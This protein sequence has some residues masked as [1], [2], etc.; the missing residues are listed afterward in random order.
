VEGFV[1]DQ[2]GNVVVRQDRDGDVAVLTLAHPP[3]NALSDAVRTG[4]AQGL[5]AALADPAVRAVVIRGEGRGFS[6]GADIAEFGRSRQALR[7]GELCLAIEN[8]AKPVIAAIHGMALGGGLELALAAHYR[9]AAETAVL[10]LPEVNLG[11][12]PGAGGTQRLPRLIGARDALR[13]MLTGVPITATEAQ[14]LG[15]VDRVVAS[16]PTHAA[17]TEAAL[18]MAAQGLTPRPTGAVRRGLQDARAYLAAVNEARA[19]QAANRLPAPARIV[20]CVEAALLFPLPQ[21]LQA[22]ETAF[23][24]LVTTPEAAG[25][26]HAFFA[27][28]RAQ[29]LP[30][31]AAAIGI[32]PIASLGLWGVGEG[33]VEMA[34]QALT[35]GMRVVLA[36]PDRPALVEAL[37]QIAGWQDAAVAAGRM[38]E[39]A[40]DADWVRLV[41]SVSPE[42]LAGADVTL[43]AAGAGVLPPSAGNAPV[44]VLGAAGQGDGLAITVAAGPGGVSELALGATAAP[45]AVAR[46]AALARR[47]NWRLVPVGPGGPVELGL[48]QALDGAVDHLKT[49][50]FSAQAVAD[51]QRAWGSLKGA[52]KSGAADARIIAVCLAALAAEGAR[53]LQDGRVRRPLEVDAI[54]LLLGLVPRWIG[55]PMFQ[56]DQRGVLVL[57]QDLIALAEHA[58]VFLPPVLIDRMIAD[59]QTFAGLNG[60]RV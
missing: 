30:A 25:L 40:R 32:K 50:G 52:G 5:Q 38:T 9:I 44:A 51:A 8:A 54:A 7:L 29:Q 48:R 31:A 28:R 21:G 12:L 15:L 3:V 59:G 14:A 22:E 49:E 23:A 18:A 16:G 2:S 20:D 4:L 36:S 11:L 37:E 10:G 58:P 57:R 33:V 35:A 45:Q 13:L 55:G 26:R 1:Q 46:L 34:G 27:E 17:L 41:T 53:M 6:A 19:A 56:A 43:R 24:D 42:P 47:L 39:A 60:L